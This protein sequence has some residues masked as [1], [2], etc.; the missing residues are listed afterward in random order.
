MCIKCALTCFPTQKKTIDGEKN[1]LG[2]GVHGL[3][4]PKRPPRVFPDMQ[5]EACQEEIG[6]LY[7]YFSD[8]ANLN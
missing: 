3:A 8:W 1:H 6:T 4:L 7:L 5:E 2:Y